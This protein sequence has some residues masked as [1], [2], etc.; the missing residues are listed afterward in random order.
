MG[1]GIGITGRYSTVRGG[2]E[3]CFDPKKRQAI[4]TDQPK[5]IQNSDKVKLPSYP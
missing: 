1:Q 4:R 3:A 2:W 5:K